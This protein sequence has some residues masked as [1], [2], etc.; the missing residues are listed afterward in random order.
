MRWWWVGTSQTF[1][2]L[3]PTVRTPPV[4]VSSEE[5]VAVTNTLLRRRVELG[6]TKKHYVMGNH[7]DRLDRY[8]QDRAPEMNGLSVVMGC[9][10]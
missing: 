1:T 5:E 6:F 7:E 9:C 2:A 10:N 4:Q 8:I 3:A